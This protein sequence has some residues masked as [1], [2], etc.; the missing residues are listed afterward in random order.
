MMSRPRVELTIMPL[1]VFSWL[2]SPPAVIQR[3]PP[4][5]N[6]SRAK[7]PTTPVNPRIT[8]P[9]SAARSV[10]CNGF[11]SVAEEPAVGPPPPLGVVPGAEGVGASTQVGGGVGA[12]VKPSPKKAHDQWSLAAPLQWEAQSLAMVQVKPL[13]SG[14]PLVACVAVKQP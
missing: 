6:M 9:M 7:A 8:R 11:S 10:V 2:S 14:G 13:V 4:T 12:Q 5:T 3:M 1:A